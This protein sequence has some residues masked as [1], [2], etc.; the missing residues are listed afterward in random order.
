MCKQCARGGCTFYFRNRGA[1]TNRAL[2]SACSPAPSQL[3]FRVHPPTP[4]KGGL[5]RSLL[6]FA[7]CTKCAFH[8]KTELK[9]IIVGLWV[10][11]ACAGRSTRNKDS[12]QTLRLSPFGGLLKERLFAFQGQETGQG[13]LAA[14]LLERTWRGRPLTQAQEAPAPW[15]VPAYGPKRPRASLGPQTPGVPPQTPGYPPDP[16]GQTKPRSIA[17]LGHYNPRIPGG[18]TLPHRSDGTLGR[19]PRSEPRAPMQMV[20]GA[21]GSLGFRV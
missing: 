3:G 20:S 2:A 12:Q 14:E 10:L 7:L 1:P 19:G 21:L 16:P 13:R 11:A 9:W 6:P 8:R 4:L 5:S 15:N 18:F 17:E